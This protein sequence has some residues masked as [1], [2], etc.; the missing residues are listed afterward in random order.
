MTTLTAVPQASARPAT[1]FARIWRIVRLH[2]LSWR[3][4]LL[5]PWVVLVGILLVNMAIWYLII[6]ASHTETLQGTRYTGSLSYLFIY[7]TV[8]A[9]QITNLSFGFALGMSSSRRDFFLGTS[10]FF[11]VHAAQFTV[12]IVLLS[13]LEQWT[14]G[15]GVGGHMFQTAY[16]GYGPIWQRAF[17]VFFGLLAALFIGS[18]FAAVFVRWRA[19]GLYLAFGA[20]AFI[21]L[22]ALAL[23][24]FTHGWPETGAW[25]ARNRALGVVAW[26]IPVSALCGVIGFLALRRA[27]PRS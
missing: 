13:Y 12:G 19:Y 17:T 7:Q 23:I 2:Y 22:G 1:A 16:L 24:T 18:I 27:V 11:V 21:I 26:S 25:F 3:M 9:V 14:H 4:T 20:V 10:L 5:F 8:V 15:W 6:A